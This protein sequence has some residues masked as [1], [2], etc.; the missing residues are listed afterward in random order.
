MRC[1]SL[2]TVQNVLWLLG[3]EEEFSA[4]FPALGRPHAA[5]IRVLRMAHA[6][7]LSRVCP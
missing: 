3:A 4:P 5:L 7:R 6:C 1:V 2:N